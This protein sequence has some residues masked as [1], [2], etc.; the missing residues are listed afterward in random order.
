MALAFATHNVGQR[1]IGN[2]VLDRP[3][4][5]PDGWNKI[6]DVM[7]TDVRDASGKGGFNAAL[8]MLEPC[9]LDLKPSTCVHHSYVQMFK[10]TEELVDVLKKET[11][12]G[13][14]GIMGLGEKMSKSHLERFQTFERLPPKQACLALADKSL[15]AADW[16]DDVRKYA[17]KHFRMISG[18]YG[19][20][21]PYDDVKPVRDMPMNARIKTKKGLY[22][23]EFWGDSITKQVSK[24]LKEISHGNKGGHCCLVSCLSE[25]YMQAIKAHELPEGTQLVEIVFDDCPEEV[26]A[27]ARCQY[28]GWA[29]ENKVCTPEGFR[30]FKSQEWSL[31]ERRCTV[32]K[33]FYTWIG[34]DRKLKKS[35]KEKDGDKE[36][37]KKGKDGDGG[38]DRKAKKRKAE[39]DTQDFSDVESGE[40]KKNKAK[41]SSKVAQ[42]FSD[43]ESGSEVAEKNKKLIKRR[44]DEDGSDEP[45]GKKKSKAKERKRRSDSRD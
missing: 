27:K 2:K 11:A 32:G 37:E 39:K 44:K 12:D 15:G 29:T 25:I 20:L 14:R 43:M 17:E 30:D 9:G 5:A 16:N 35:K 33:I 19:V 41:K 38:D 4:C 24:D 13:I 10:R 23:L 36:K 21:R 34:D 26:A 22:L 42:D 45:R 40:Y 3:Y 8:V 7:A 18:L 1:A 31:D 6:D 28:A